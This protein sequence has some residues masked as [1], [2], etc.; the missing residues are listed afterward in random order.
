[1][2]K[3][4]IEF[5]AVPE[6]VT[7]AAVP[8]SPV[9]VVPTVTVAEYHPCLSTINSVFAVLPAGMVKF[10]MAFSA[11]PEL[12]TEAAEPGSPVVVVPTETVAEYHPCHQYH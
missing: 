6:L 5:S 7:E 2:V 3:F 10:K 12:V 9:V 8:G 11:V 4:K 1:M